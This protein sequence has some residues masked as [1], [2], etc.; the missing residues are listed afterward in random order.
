[1]SRYHRVGRF[2]FSKLKTRTQPDQFPEK[3]PKRIAGLLAPKGQLSLLLISLCVALSC[4]D[5]E[6][7][8][9]KKKVTVPAKPALPPSAKPKELYLP[10]V[11][12][13]QVDLSDAQSKALSPT[14]INS[15]CPQEMVSIE[16][17]YCVDRYETRLIRSGSTEKLSPYYPP[18]QRKIKKIFNQ[19][20]RNHGKEDT[21]Y[22]RELAVPFPPDFSLRQSFKFAATSEKDTTP[23][24]Y[25]SRHDAEAACLASGKRLCTVSEWQKA[26]RGQSQRKFPY[27]DT[28][29]QG[30]CNVGRFSHPA[31]LLHADSSRNH[32]DPRL[33]RTRDAQGALLRKTGATPACQSAW[34][35][36]S[37]FDMV[38]N[39]DEWVS[40]EDGQFLGGFYA[41]AT[42]EGCDSQ[43][44]V[45]GPG[46]RDYSLGT[47]CCSDAH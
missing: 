24:G 8:S 19:Y 7:A 20:F 44:T 13:H 34:G 31:Q 17:R 29:Q 15:P 6:K 4:Q 25:L 39:L 32:L 11:E 41:R 9:E 33:N 10:T 46:Y 42:R 28:Y 22:G 14:Q 35:D 45:H 18:L 23:S 40:E 43:I 37:I 47:R 1:M 16:G 38:G 36:D 3:R 26:C 30:V 27:G 5:G 21:A 2:R 12:K